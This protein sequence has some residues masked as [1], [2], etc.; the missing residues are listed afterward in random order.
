MTNGSSAFLVDTNVLV[1]AYEPTAEDKRDRAIE[2]LEFLGTRQLSSLNAQILGE[3]FVTVTRKIPTPMT[4]A[5]AEHSVTNYTRSWITYDLT[6]SI[7]LEAVRG[8]QR[9]R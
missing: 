7:V 1:Y 6:K 9:H 2:V 5:K 4:E 8:L 3:F